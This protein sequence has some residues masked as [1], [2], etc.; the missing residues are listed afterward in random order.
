MPN[1]RVI[2]VRKQVVNGSLHRHVHL[3]S[4]RD[5]WCVVG[6][7]I[8]HPEE[9]NRFCLICEITEIEVKDESPLPADATQAA[10]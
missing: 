7:L 10:T 1:F 9:W 3:L 4:R 6:V 5:G 2:V 8:L